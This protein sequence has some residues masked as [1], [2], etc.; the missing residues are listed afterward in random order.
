[1]QIR[2]K[3]VILLTTILLFITISYYL[4]TSSD[5]AYNDLTPIQL[6]SPFSNNQSTVRLDG[7]KATLQ[8]HLNLL[9]PEIKLS[10]ETASKETYSSLLSQLEGITEYN[11]LLSSIGS[12]TTLILSPTYKQVFRI[13]QYLSNPELESKLRPSDFSLLQVCQD[14]IDK[15]IIE[16]MSD[17]D[18]ELAIHD[19]IIQT[20]SYDYDNLVRN[21]VPDIAHTAAGALINHS[22]VC[23]GYSEAI[24]L[25]LSLVDIKCKIVTG[26]SNTNQPHSWNIVELDNVW[27]MLDTTYDDPVIFNNSGERLESLSYDYFNVTDEILMQDHVWDKGKWPSTTYNYFNVSGQIINTYDQFKDYIKN[28]IQSGSKEILC[29]ITD[30]DPSIYKLDFIFD[31]YRGNIQFAAPAYNSGSLTIWLS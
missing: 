12:D 6:P 4:H 7:L 2:D 22:A 3:V 24:Q 28:E 16:S 14:I 20:T 26:F 29:Y 15:I 1:M 19:Y 13:T 9:E 17:Y 10:V 27:Y 31:F 8:S 21:T 25:L 23:D 30:Y 5:F 11:F 18:K